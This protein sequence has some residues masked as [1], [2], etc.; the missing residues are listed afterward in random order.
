MIHILVGGDIK[1]K[2][3]FMKELTS[4]RESFFLRGEE[5][6]KDQIINYCYSVDLFSGSPVIIGENILGENNIS[7]TTKELSLMQASG[8]IFVFNEDK[9]LKTIQDKYKKYGSIKI[10]ED[11]K[12][13]SKEKFNIFSLTDSFAKKD[14]VGTWVLY[15]KSLED[16]VEPE[17]IAG[18]L[19][20][21]IKSL[22]LS[23][24][25]TFTKNELKQQSSR[26]ITLYHKA[27]RGEEDMTVS[28]EQFILSSLSSK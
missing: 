26:I 5:I 9:L 10:F 28:L 2:S 21:K 16:G 3:I 22:L 25:N 13:I 27:H 15:N 6:N 23:S 18:V 24:S 19:F 11:K 14:K 17:A 20:W 7:F 1:N 12:I 8:T 4:G